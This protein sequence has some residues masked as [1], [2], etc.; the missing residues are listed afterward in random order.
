ML[1]P[2][3]LGPQRPG[4]WS[5][6]Q[7]P[8]SNPPGGGD[9]DKKPSRSSTSGS[10]RDKGPSGRGSGSGPKRSSSSEMQA[11][12]DAVAKHTNKPSRSMSGPTPKPPPPPEPDALDEETVRRKTGTIVDEL[13]DNADIKVL[14]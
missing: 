6:N 9:K 11:V 12:L 3:S 4:V 14:V 7:P 2:P 8:S 5:R 10:K 1:G 13:A